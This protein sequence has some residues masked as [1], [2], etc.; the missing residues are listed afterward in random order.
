M[1]VFVPEYDWNSQWSSVEKSVKEGVA[2][3]DYA[4]GDEFKMVRLTVHACT[5]YKIIDGKPVATAI[6]FP[7]GIKEA[8]PTPRPATANYPHGSLGEECSE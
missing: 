8:D 4:E 5:T 2:Y 7:V 6:S 3:G 1:D